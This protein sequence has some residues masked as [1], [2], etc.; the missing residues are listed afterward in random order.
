MKIIAS[1][2]DGTINYKGKISE[3]DQRAIAKFRKAGN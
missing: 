3:E 1:D 2:Y